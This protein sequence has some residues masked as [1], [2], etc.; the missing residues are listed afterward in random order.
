MESFQLGAAPL[1]STAV[2]NAFLTVTDTLVLVL[3]ADAHI[4][5]MN[6]AAE[7]LFGYTPEELRG[8]SV[9]EALVPEDVRAEARL[10]WRRLWDGTASRHFQTV[11]TTKRG[12]RRYVSWSNTVVEAEGHD[13]CV[14]ATGVDQTQ[15][16]QLEADVVSVSETERQRIGQELHDGLASDL[17][18]ATMSLETL[19]HRVE[20]TFSPPEDLMDRLQR[21]EDTVR[22]GANRA[23][24]LS[25]LLA[26]T[27]VEPDGL[28]SAL[29]D[30]LQKQEQVAP[31]DCALHLPEDEMPA[32]P[33]A[34]VAGHLYRIAQEAVRN[35]I[36]H[37]DPDRVEVRLTVQRDEAPRSPVVRLD[38]A[39]D[40]TGLPDAMA[41]AL[42]GPAAEGCDAGGI[43]FQLMQYRADLIGATLSV[44]AAE[45][46]GTTVQCA[47]PLDDVA[48]P[49]T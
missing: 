1:S 30:L 48:L 14:V 26:S 12:D 9:F 4:A 5:Y 38:V 39:D 36:K 45:G 23:R 46:E 17:V 41:E 31:T 44:D 37:A 28:P 25:H 35:A 21:I 20:Q 10:Y 7:S 24:S 49:P 47:L 42:S 15:R 22:E 27:H 19:Q 11:V 32:L 2:A 6:P 43:G 33:N 16:R 13:P 3:D 34:N 29:R 8:Q 40:G 18:A